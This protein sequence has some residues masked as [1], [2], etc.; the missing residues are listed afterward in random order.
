MNFAGSVTKCDK[1]Q[2]RNREITSS[3][4]AAALRCFILA[5]ALFDHFLRL[6]AGLWCRCNEP[7]Q[8]VGYWQ[9]RSGTKFDIVMCIAV[10]V[11]S[12]PADKQMQRLID[13]L[14]ISY[15]CRIE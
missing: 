1:E 12:D 15:H 3:M 7:L 2:T 5:K 11:C 13:F 4:P 9:L 14:L 8:V 10:E 6:V